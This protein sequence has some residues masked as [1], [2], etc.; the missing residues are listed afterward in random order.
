M[1]QWVMTIAQAA[2]TSPTNTPQGTSPAASFFFPAMMLA[3]LVFFF[4]TARSQKKREKRERDGMHSRLAKN[5]RV[6]T[7][8]GVIG[9]VHAVKDDEVVLK[10][11]ES[12]NTKMTFLKTAI[13]RILGDSQDLSAA[14]R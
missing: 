8:G 14:K 4:L 12:T 7:V 13:Q 6:V 2:P 5:D 3:L 11:D 9:T 10:V 1:N